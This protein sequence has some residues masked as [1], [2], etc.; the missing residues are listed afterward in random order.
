[1]Y[2]ISKFLRVYF[3]TAH[4]AT[5]VVVRIKGLEPSR[6]R[7]Q[8]LSLAC[9]PISPYAHNM[10]FWQK[11]K[12]LITGG[13]Y[14]CLGRECGIW[15][16]GAVTLASFQDW[17]LKPD[18]A[19]SPY[20]IGERGEIRTHSSRG[21]GF[22]ARHDSPTS[23]PSHIGGIGRIRTYSYDAPNIAVYHWLTTPYLAVLRRIELRF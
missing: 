19:N 14:E 21:N 6:H 16:H 11:G 10:P 8:I 17:C 9:L 1:M 20:Y 13:H 15:T 4:F 5:S 7:H 22:T 3:P 2:T 23:S 12:K 18:S